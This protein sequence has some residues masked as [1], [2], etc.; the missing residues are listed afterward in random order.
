MTKPERKAVHI[1]AGIDKLKVKRGQLERAVEML[2]SEL[3]EC[4]RLAEDKADMAYVHKWLGQKLKKWTALK[5]VEKE[6][7]ELEVKMR[8]LFVVYFLSYVCF[9]F[10]FSLDVFDF[11]LSPALRL[12]W[13]LLT[14]LTYVQHVENCQHISMNCQVKLSAC[15]YLTSLLLLTNYLTCFA[16]P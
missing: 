4:I 6:I 9:D 1:V 3:A 13:Q 14:V 5:V 12:C 15:L 10:V 7:Q 16:K 2:E 8:K 11:A